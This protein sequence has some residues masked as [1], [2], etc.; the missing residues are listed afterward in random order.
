MGATKL[1]MDDDDDMDMDGED[2]GGWDFDDADDD[3][4]ADDDGTNGGQRQQP[5]SKFRQFPLPLKIKELSIPKI[6]G[7]VRSPTSQTPRPIDTQLFYHD[8]KMPHSQK[9]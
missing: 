3:D 2:G 4:K 1:S 8:L 7:R 6:Y 9:C 5:N